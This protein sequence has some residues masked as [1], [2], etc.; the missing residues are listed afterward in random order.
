M[1]STQAANA[2]RRRLLSAE[3][4][5]GWVFADLFL[6]LFLVGLGSAVP[7][8]PKPSGKP[9]PTPTANVTPTKKPDPPIVGMKTVPALLSVAVDAEALTST[10][11]SGTREGAIACRR[12]RQSAAPLTGE[13]AGLVLVFGGGPDVVHGQAVA[14][15]LARQ[16]P[17]ANLSLF[18]RSTPYRAFWDGTL[19]YGKVRLEVFVFTTKKTK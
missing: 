19:D 12:L 5:A 6:V 14:R 16:L 7:V 3:S 8:A 18:A 10:G 9:S 1:T 15:S 17:C 13:R 11:S 2:R 4:V